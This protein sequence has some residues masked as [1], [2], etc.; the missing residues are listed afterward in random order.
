MAIFTNLGFAAEK[1]KKCLRVLGQCLGKLRIILRKLL[2]HR[3]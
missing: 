3:L 1:V 2:D